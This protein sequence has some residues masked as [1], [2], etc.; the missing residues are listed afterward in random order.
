MSTSFNV[1]YTEGD[2]I[3]SAP[4]KKRNRKSK[5]AN[6]E[7]YKAARL[8]QSRRYEAKR[9]GKR[10]RK[11]IT[12]VPVSE[13][14][15]EERLK[16]NNYS[17]EWSKK[18]R[19]KRNKYCNSWLER[20]LDKKE[21]FAESSSEKHLVGLTYINLVKSSLGC[22]MCREDESLKLAFHH[23][24][25]KNKK[26]GISNLTKY[27]FNDIDKE[28]AKCEVLCH[29]CHRKLHYE[30]RQVLKKDWVRKDNQARYFCNLEYCNV[31]KIEAGCK[32][33]GT[34]DFR[35]LDFHHA[36]RAGKVACVSALYG[37]NVEK[38]YDEILKC[39][40]LCANCHSIVT[41]GGE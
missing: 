29:N 33:C 11:K 1:A 5:Y 2:V 27:S 34:N 8:E 38:L 18:N 20:N 21:K 12:Y 3:L 14:S 17:N 24:D 28:I 16:R 40:V 37:S 19:D 26:C 23:F 13:L 41:H 31:L 25:R 15:D 4:K 9:K 35:C 7:E 10:V 22:S 6:E 36:Q 32:N 30:E 39:E